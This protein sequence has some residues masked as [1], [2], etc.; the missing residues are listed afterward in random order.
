MNNTKKWMWDK[1]KFRAKTSGIFNLE[2]YVTIYECYFFIVEG[3]RAIHKVLIKKK[4]KFFLFHSSVSDETEVGCVRPQYKN[5]ATIIS[6]T[7]WVFFVISSH[8]IMIISISS[9]S[10]ACLRV[11]CN[12]NFLGIKIYAHECLICITPQLNS[13][14]SH[15]R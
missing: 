6:C 10:P 14:P 5:F 4:R 2:Q 11:V 7:I 8:H 1:K 13:S 15:S 3:Q 12:F 9:Y